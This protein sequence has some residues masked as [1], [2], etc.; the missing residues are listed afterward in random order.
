VIAGVDEGEAGASHQVDDGSRDEHIAGTCERLDPLRQ[1]H[2]D[3]ADVIS[4]KLDLAGVDAEAVVRPRPLSPSRTATANG[5]ARPGP[6]N[7]ARTPSPVDFTLRPRNR[8]MSR[9]TITS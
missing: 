7:I 3:A 5:T 6:S 4:A 2:G 9:S 1:V 8:S